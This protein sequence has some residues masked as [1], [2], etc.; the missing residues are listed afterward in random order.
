MVK[1]VLLVLFV[2]LIA[3]CAWQW[4][5]V[6]YGVDQAKGQ[7]KVI[8]EAKPVE[9]FLADPAFPDSLKEKLRLVQEVRGFAMNELGLSQS[10]NYTTLYDQHGETILWNVSACEPY[11]LKAYS[12]YFPFLGSMPYKGFFDLA[13][14]KTEA[15]QLKAEGY[16]VRIR[17]VSGWSTL[18]I[19]KD[20]ILSNMLERSDGA[21]AEVIIHELT[22]A[23]IFVKDEIDFNENLASFIGERGAELFLSRRYGD[24]SSQLIS[25][26][27]SL[28]DQRKLTAHILAGGQ[29]LDSIYTAMNNHS[30]DFKD[31]VKHQAMRKIASQMD[32][33]SFFNSKYRKIFDEK[34]PNNAYFMAFKRYHSQEDTLT[35]IYTHHNEDLIR[36]IAAMKAQ[37]EK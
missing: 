21:L 27:N 14:A 17:T 8:L 31:S 35:S 24:R 29:H 1:R 37:Y 20:P 33:V 28:T 32:T 34:L 11:E 12:W 15:D 30:A 2:I 6:R 23:T 22:H 3:L 26:K 25:Y 36:L 18:G 10:D 16:D 7:M 19:L 13:K 4:Q 9:E 5:L